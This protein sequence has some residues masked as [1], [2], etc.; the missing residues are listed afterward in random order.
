MAWAGVCIS[1]S[2][3]P[4]NSSIRTVR[5]TADIAYSEN[6]EPM[7]A[8]SS[9]CCFAPRYCAIRTVPPTAMPTTR[10]VMMNS[11]WLPVV[12]AETDDQHIHDVINSL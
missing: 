8:E 10:K 9:W 2:M 3:L 11:I 12:T 5:T 6:M 7:V 1:C 4:E